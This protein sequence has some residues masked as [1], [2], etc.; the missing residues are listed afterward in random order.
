VKGRIGIHALKVDVQNLLLVS[1]HLKVA[2]EDLFALSVKLKLQNGRMKGFDLQGK[3]NGVV[4]HFDGHRGA[5]ASVND[6]RQFAI[7]TEAAAR[8][9]PL[10]RTAGGDHFGG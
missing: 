2:Q 5:C 10:N 6:A 8:T 1:V 9:R 3:Q 4:I 7:A